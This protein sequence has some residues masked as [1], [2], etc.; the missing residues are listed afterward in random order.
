MS[1][2][3]ETNRFTPLHGYFVLLVHDLFQNFFSWLS[4]L[5]S[6][7]FIGLLLLLAINDA[8]DKNSLKI[9]EF[10]LLTLSFAI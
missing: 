1:L 5:L 4:M 7:M 8:N 3:F 10:E 2:K 9:D 6:D